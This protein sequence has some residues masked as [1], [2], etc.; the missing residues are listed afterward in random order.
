MKVIAVFVFLHCAATELCLPP[1]ICQS[2]KSEIESEASKSAMVICD[3]NSYVTNFF[4][5]NDCTGESENYPGVGF[6]GGMLLS[7]IRVF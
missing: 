4:G 3:G 6:L 2:I 5:T 1:N 7:A